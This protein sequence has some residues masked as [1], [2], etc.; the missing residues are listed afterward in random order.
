LDIYELNAKELSIGS[1]EMRHLIA[2]FLL[3]DIKANNDQDSGDIKK[4]EETHSDL[5]AGVYEGLYR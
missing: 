3:E 5:I 2:G 1:I 4:S